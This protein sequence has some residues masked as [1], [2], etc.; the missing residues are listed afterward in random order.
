MDQP[1]HTPSPGPTQALLLRLREKHG[2]SQ[3]EIAGAAD[4]T[5]A[6]V[7]RWMRGLV[8]DSVDDVFRLQELE[9]K[10]EAAAASTTEGAKH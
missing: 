6:R 5:Q 3:D 4:M 1:N 7:S 9:R 8:P 10:M 2:M